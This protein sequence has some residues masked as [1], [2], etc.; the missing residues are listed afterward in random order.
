MT[1]YAKTLNEAE[2]MNCV[3]HSIKACQAVLA[4][5]F[6]NRG[7]IQD[8]AIYWAI[9]RVQFSLETLVSLIEVKLKE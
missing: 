8:R 1:T 9:S 7:C 5:P 3:L 6:K 2:Y 4:E